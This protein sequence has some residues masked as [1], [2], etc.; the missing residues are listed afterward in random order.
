MPYRLLVCAAVLLYLCVPAQAE[1]RIKKERPLKYDYFGEQSQTK[2]TRPLAETAPVQVDDEG[3]EEDDEI[4][5]HIPTRRPAI[6]PRPPQGRMATAAVPELQREPSPIQLPPT[7]TVIPP[8]TPEGQLIAGAR[9]LLQLENEPA[10]SGLIQLD[11]AGKA[12]LPLVGDLALAG[13]TLLE[14]EQ[15]VIAAYASG[16]FVAPRLRLTLEDTQ[17]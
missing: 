10:L 2:P 17:P 5:L 15:T 7:A 4:T 3:A 12:R 8:L 9:L 11:P 1:L 14:A 6:K 13:K 16:Y